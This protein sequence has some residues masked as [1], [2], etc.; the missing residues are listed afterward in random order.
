MTL[1]QSELSELLEAVR[2]G[3]GIDVVRRGVELVLQALISAEASEF[4]GAQPFERTASR[5]NLRNGTRERLLSTKAGD[6][7]LQI[8]RCA[9]AASSPPCLSVV[10]ASTGRSSRW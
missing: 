2:A 10:G 5:T 7:Q 3:G 6:V 9:R 4:I 8:R 1:S